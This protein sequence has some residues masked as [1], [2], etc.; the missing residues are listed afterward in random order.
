MGASGPYRVGPAGL[1]GRG[2]WPVGLFGILLS[3]CLSRWC[4]LLSS[5]D[6]RQI[7][8]GLSADCL[9]PRCGVSGGIVGSAGAFA[10]FWVVRFLV[11]ALAVFRAPFYL[12]F[13]NLIFVI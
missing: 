6:A 9:P 12:R 5:L 3:A 10:C 4:V 1:P 8:F 7:V 13:C 11:R 2:S